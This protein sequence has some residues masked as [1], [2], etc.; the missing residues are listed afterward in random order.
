MFTDVRHVATAVYHNA[1]FRP[2]MSGDLPLTANIQHCEGHKLDMTS[3]DDAASRNRTTGL[4]FGRGRPPEGACVHQ[5]C[6]RSGTGATMS[7]T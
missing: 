3:T 1:A 7:L 2:G 4:Q 5:R 6:V